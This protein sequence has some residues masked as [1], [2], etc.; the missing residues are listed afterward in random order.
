MNPTYDPQAIEKHW[1]PLW[2]QAG[3]FQ[4]SGKGTPYCIMLPPPNVTG[5]LHMGH[6]F[7]MTLM[8]ALIRY[9][10]MLGDNTL[11][12]AGTDHAGIATQMVV[13]RQLQQ[14]GKT[15]LELG[16]NEFVARVW[17]WKAKSDG[18]IKQQ[19]RRL[20][21]SADWTRERFTLDDSISVA[22]QEVFVKLYEQ[23]LIYR[24]KRLVNWDPVLQTAVSDL[25]VINEEQTGQLW[26]IRYPLVDGSGFIT[27]ATSRPETLFGDVAVAVHPDDKRYLKLIGK[28][29]KLPLTERTIPIIADD[30][31]L[32]EFGSGAVKITPAHDFNDYAMA[33][34]HNLAMINIFTAD[35][36][37]NEFVPKSYQGLE[38]FRAR[39]DAIK[40]LERLELI[41][42]IEP[43]L[44]K[45][46]KGEKTGAILEPYLTDQWFI[47][48]KKLAEPAI[49]AVKNGKIKFVPEHWS[50]LYFQWLENI[51]D[52]CIS[53]QLWWGHRI[54]AW[55]DASGQV[56]VGHSEAEIRQRHHLPK[57]IQLIQDTD[58]LDTWFSSALWP[59]ATLGWPEAT[60]ELKTFYPT[61]V[62]V[63][64]FDIIFFWVA[65]MIMMGLHFADN[66][67]FKEV[68]ITGL[69]LDGEGQKNV[70]IQRQ[71]VGS[72][73]FN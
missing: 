63:T 45:L 40:E 68:Y 32:M 33:L 67:P 14:E 31:V 13:E 24:G 35:A 48:T 38:R 29:I 73:R 10:R 59:F 21:A 55:Y 6:G 41:E 1:Y 46:P 11:W 51:Q 4:P 42:K 25:E 66:I 62:L 70:E 72:T 60:P 17:E 50:K 26:H 19:M 65:R 61:N 30:A 27:V 57:E 56:Y 49:A 22:V 3:Y 54:P 44:I 37:L 53:R 18:T 71:C 64:G 8:D 15:R 16:R 36:H 34:R 58:V 7:Q 2:E 12:Q 20:G 5:T 28:Q 52:W 43:H 47:A 23:G 69:I 39:Q 9:H